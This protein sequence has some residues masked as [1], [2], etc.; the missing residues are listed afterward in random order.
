[1]VSRT[2]SLRLKHQ[3]RQRGFQDSDFEIEMGLA[4]AI[5]N[6]SKEDTCLLP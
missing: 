4:A 1:M 5:F 2:T 6:I 3:K